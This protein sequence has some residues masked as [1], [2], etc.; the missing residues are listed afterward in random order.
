MLKYLA[1]YTHRVAISNQRLVSLE[2]GRVTFRWKNY[3]HAREPATMTMPAEEFIRRFLLHV[4]PK[5]L[6]K[7]RHF[8]FSKPGAEPLLKP[9]ALHDRADAVGDLIREGLTVR[10][11]EDFG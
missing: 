2:H 6:V 7:V 1:R 11:H 5:G 3:A 10:E 4:L 8:G 9:V